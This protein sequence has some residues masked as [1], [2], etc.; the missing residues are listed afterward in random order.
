M[1]QSLQT[2]LIFISIVSQNTTWSRLNITSESFDH[3]VSAHNFCDNI[4]DVVQNFHHRISDTQ[5]FQW[6]AS[7]VRPG[8]NHYGQSVASRIN[9]CVHAY[10]YGRDLLQN[11]IPD[12]Q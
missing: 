1:Y 11:T 6:N 4:Y 10:R 3:I 5:Q 12:T 9:N 8:I 7:H 2:Y